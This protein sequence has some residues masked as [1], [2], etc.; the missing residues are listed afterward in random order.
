MMCQHQR[1]RLTWGIGRQL[2]KYCNACHQELAVL[3]IDRAMMRDC[4]V[5]VVLEMG[6]LKEFYEQDD[7]AVAA[8]SERRP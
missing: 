6:T 5:D 7:A 8:I 3:D 2:G 1:V 4:A